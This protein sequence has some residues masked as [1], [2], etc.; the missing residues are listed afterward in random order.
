M[1]LAGRPRQPLAKHAATGALNHNPKRFKGR[2]EPKPRPI[3]KPSV[4][5]TKNE[6]K[7]WHAFCREASWFTEADR[8]LLEQACKYRAQSFSRKGLSDTA[9]GKYVS[10]LSRLGLTPTDRSRVVVPDGAET[11]SADDYLN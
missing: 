4:G 8:S 3:G 1:S 7:Y 11:S 6:V 5:L 2:K 9:V 10:I